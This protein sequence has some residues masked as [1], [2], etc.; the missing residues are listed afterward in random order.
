[1]LYMERVDAELASRDGGPTIR[2]AVRSGRIAY[3]SGQIK[4]PFQYG[5]SDLGSGVIGCTVIESLQGGLQGLS[6]RG[7]MQW[8]TQSRRGRG[9]GLDG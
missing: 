4:G 3:C 5:R 2:R 1:M 7:V 9:G 8:E 6:R